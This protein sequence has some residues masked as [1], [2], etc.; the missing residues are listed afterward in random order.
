MGANYVR[1]AMATTACRIERRHWQ[2]NSASARINIIPAPA[3][4]RR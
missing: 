2:K 3:I 4:W 1:L